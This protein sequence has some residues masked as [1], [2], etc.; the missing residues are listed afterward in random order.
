M[1]ASETLKKLAALPTVLVLESGKSGEPEEVLNL[2]NGMRAR[3]AKDRSGWFNGLGK[4]KVME[5]VFPAS[6]ME[7]DKKSDVHVLDTTRILSANEELRLE[8]VWVAQA[9]ALPLRQGAE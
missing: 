8:A 6:S 3:L 5:L 9:G 7:H 2:L 1:S 4:D